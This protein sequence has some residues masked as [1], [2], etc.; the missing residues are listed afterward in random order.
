VRAEPAAADAWN[1]LGAT[2][3]RQRRHADAEAAY[4]RAIAIRPG[5]EGA[6]NNLG[7]LLRQTGR[8][9][10]ARETYLETLRHHPR[11]AEAWNNLGA[12][13]AA[14]GDYAGALR[15]YLELLEI[16]PGYGYALG[17]A[18]NAKSML[19]DWSGRDALLRRLAEGISAGQP[20]ATPFVLLS[21]IDDP[22]LQLA[23]ARTWSARYPAAPA[24][25]PR[26]PHSRIRVAYLSADFRDHPVG[27]QIAGL[28]E[29]HD[30]RRFEW[31]GVHHGR[32]AAGDATHRRLRAAFDNYLDIADLADTEAARRLLALEIDIVV[33]LGGHTLDSRPSLLALRPA[34]I[35]VNYLGYPGSSG[36]DWIDYLL[37]DDFIVPPERRAGYSERVVRLPGSFWISDSG[38]VAPGAVANRQAH[39]LPES[40]FVFCCFNHN[41]K[42]NPAIFD[43]W[44]RVLQQVE[45]SVL[46]LLKA[47][48]EVETRLRE[49]ARARGLG[50]E[51]LVFAPRLP[52]AEHLARHCCADLF[53]DTLP[54]N[55]ITTTSVALSA[56]LPV[57]TCAG[58]SFAARG[59]GSL[60]RAAGLAQL[61]TDDLETYEARA[62]ALATQPQRLAQL[63]AQ[64]AQRLDAGP[65][66][67]TVR[68]ARHLEA[69][70]REMCARWHAGAGPADFAVA[71]LT[72]PA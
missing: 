65:L 70:Y 59:A 15:C 32:P 64:L 11:H 71:P 12:L 48:P 41:Y 36:A 1:L 14:E 62:V 26:D 39:G 67:D 45:G 35:Q 53:L 19:C 72:P 49:E 16:S 9:A 38:R 8:H 23:C 28:I 68:V 54:F 43:V 18:A 61:I 20:T 30:R 46:W 47:Q 10:R 2:L 52:L 60:L 55:A 63:R 40:A 58:R 50:P 29:A 25:R 42:L 33:D 27:L 24:P 66:F 21:H 7:V 6:L 57:L 3:A 17:A 5:H 51:R 4:R 34:P 31:F 56:G 69:A 22:A 44:A 13:D 37:A